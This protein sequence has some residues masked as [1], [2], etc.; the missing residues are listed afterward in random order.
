MTTGIRRMKIISRPRMSDWHGDLNPHIHL[1]IT[2][3]SEIHLPEYKEEERHDVQYV[4]RVREIGLRQSF[5]RPLSGLWRLQEGTGVQELGGKEDEKRTW[6]VAS[7]DFMRTVVWFR[8]RVEGWFPVLYRL[9]SACIY[10]KQNQQSV[11]R[12]GCDFVWPAPRERERERER[13][14]DRDRDRQTD[15]QTDRDNRMG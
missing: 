9:I 7:S 4:P 11:I 1:I 8:D 5:S 3:T 13:D 15:R 10:R 12:T 2:S 6:L 14:R